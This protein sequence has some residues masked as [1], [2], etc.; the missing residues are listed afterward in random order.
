[1]KVLSTVAMEA[2]EHNPDLPVAGYVNATA[3]VV[4]TKGEGFYICNPFD[5][6]IEARDSGEPF[7]AHMVVGMK[8]KRTIIEPGTLTR[9][10]EC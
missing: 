5:E 1:M 7:V 3:W 9:I 6:I 2:P 10:E 8:P 4:P